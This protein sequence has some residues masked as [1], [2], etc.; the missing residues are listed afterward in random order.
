MRKIISPIKWLICSLAIGLFLCYLQS[1]GGNKNIK[2]S[3][4]GG[5][6]ASCI[7]TFNK[8]I[9]DDMAMW[10]DTSK[11]NGD[12][13]LD[14][15]E[16]TPN[17]KPFTPTVAP[18][19]APNILF[20]LYDD[21]GLGAWSPYGGKIKMPTMDGIA[22]DGLIYTQWHTTALCSPTR[23]TIMTGRNHH[24]NGMASITE[25][26]DGYPG[27]NGRLPDNCMPFAELLQ[28]N[29]YSTFWLGKNHNVPEVDVAPGGYRGSWPCQMGFDR[30]Y[31][32]L[33]G[34]TN[35]WYPDLVEDNHFIEAPQTPEE[36]YHLSKDLAFQAVK[37][38]RDQNA[39]NP[40]KPWYMWFCPGANH[41]PHHAPDSLIQ[42]YAKDET[43]IQGYD[44]YRTE[45]LATMVE[46][47]IL[48]KNTKETDINFLADT[49]ANPLDT[50][51]PWGDLSDSTK[52]LYIRM[53]ETFAAFSTYT[54]QQ[55]GNIIEYL[56]ESGQYENT[57][58]IYAAD[59]GTSGEGT[60]TGS[61][62]ENKFF[63]G[64]P[65]KLEENMKYLDTLGSPETYSHFPTGWAAAFSTPFKMFKRYSQFAGGTN[66]PLVMAWPKYTKN[67]Y[68]PG[69]DSLRI[70]HQYHHSTDIV[71]TLI[72]AINSSVDTN[73]YKLEMPDIAK[74]IP[75]KPL[76]GVSMLYTFNQD[77]NP[78][79]QTAK[80]VQYY[81]MLGTRGIWKDGW[82]AIA[83]HA[84]TSG[85]A[86][87]Y[88]YESDVW[89]LYHV[90]EDR[91]EYY[92]LA[93]SNPDKLNDLIHEWYKQAAINNVLPL[94]DRSAEQIIGIKRPS[95]EPD[96]N[97]HTYYPKTSA[98]PE[99]V[100]A[101]I[102][103]RSYRITASV[104]NLRSNTK[105]VLFAHGSRFGGH[106][107]Y[108]NEDRKL[109]YLYN[110]LGIEGQQY[111]VVSNET[112]PANGDHE[113]KVEFERD[114][115]YNS[116]YGESQG[117]L[118]LYIDGNVSKTMLI[119]TQPGKFT[120]SGDGLC[121]GYDSADPIT[122]NYPNLKE[123]G[124][125]GGGNA[126]DGYSR[127]KYVKVETEGDGDDAVRRRTEAKRIMLRE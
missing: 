70:R 45:I 27:A 76:S 29:G 106:T 26:A 123:K 34:E 33:G 95:S 68:A 114:T 84:P 65:D 72:E 111:E 35:N 5:N 125:F 17:W 124:K 2:S 99:G 66:D 82:K 122:V 32:F 59:N 105:G 30:F 1:C 54:D 7:D 3:D 46:K 55:V 8:Y 18:K 37:M 56:K 28:D 25:T 120:L 87:E 15:N 67:M 44:A 43:F 100:A 12:I 91:S 89:E 22:K 49:V 31:G 50:I 77:C 51:T 6:C 38:L 42:Q 48:P 108:I 16:S 126:T 24:L 57:I 47:G 101:N 102:R 110:F 94:D 52:Q 81:A 74:G 63:N 19:E 88:G 61:V 64:Y 75:Q 104:K 53:A 98:V 9:P 40:S 11:A 41:A 92:N 121:I 20:I 127:I 113:F 86:E 73:K 96:T 58:I 62:N 103:G 97:V 80:R 39:S 14:A 119:Q 115:N 10:Y 78:Y 23:S 60:P 71:P 83:L 112:I 13:Q 36:G 85:K 69:A 21:T 90:E 109:V 107:L 116:Q 4:I 117:M 93:K 118:T 79:D